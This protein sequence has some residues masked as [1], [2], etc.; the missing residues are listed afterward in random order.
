MTPPRP[1]TGTVGSRIRVILGKDGNS[2]LLLLNHDDGNQEWQSGSWTSIPNGLAKQ[3]NSCTANGRDVK[4]V[5][6]GP[7]GSGY[8]QGVKP[9][10]S[11]SHHWWGGLDVVKHAIIKRITSK[12]LPSKVA[13]GSQHSRT[14]V[15]LISGSNGYTCINTSRHL[16]TTLKQ[17]QSRGQRIHFVRL[18]TKGHYFIKHDQ[19]GQWSLANHSNNRLVQELKKK[20]VEDVAVAGDGSWIVI[21]SDY[22]VIS[23]GVD[24][25]LSDHIRDFF[26]K[27]KER[28][29]K[30]EREIKEYHDRERVEREEEERVVEEE[31]KRGE[32]EEE[33]KATTLEVPLVGK[34]TQDKEIR[35]KLEAKVE[36]L[37]DELG[38]MQAHLEVIEDH[39][40]RKES[41]RE[42]LVAQP[43]Q[44]PRRNIREN[45]SAKRREKP[46]CVICKDKAPVRA[47]V[48]C[49]HLCLCDDCALS[50]SQSPSHSRL[51]PLCRGPAR[52]TLRIYS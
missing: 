2:W 19:G 16:S 50:I 11:G 49:G 39:L 23:T 24:K 32:E 30:R 44:R 47:V 6:F 34:P 36:V 35:D 29:H 1:I 9:D 46:Q 20:K 26:R 28:N 31:S 37:Q 3:I 45:K 41:L 51:C 15:C 7:N 25:R 22:G 38:A 48:P 43:A 21:R 4:G 12:P 33:S 13:L 18:F 17:I 14:S 52:R 5:D 40:S 8:V 10:G 27:Q 42:S